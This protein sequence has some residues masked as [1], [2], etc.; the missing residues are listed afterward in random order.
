[1][2]S[3]DAKKPG[4]GPRFGVPPKFHPIFGTRRPAA[5]RV[6]L[7]KVYARGHLY[8]YPCLLYL[9]AVSGIIAGTQWAATHGLAGPRVY[10]AMLLLLLPALVGARLLF[11]AFHWEVYRHQP[12]RIWRRTE[13]GAALYGGLILSFLISLPVLPV[14]GLDVLAFWDAGAIALLVGMMFTRVGCLLNGCCIGRPSE[15]ALAFDLSD[16][17]GVRCRRLPL[18]LFEAGLCGLVLF[19]SLRLA[20]Q[21]PIGGS[22]FFTA[23]AGYGA[24]R[25]LLEPLRDTID[26]I[27]G[28]S[29]NRVIS[30]GLLALATAA[31][32]LRIVVNPAAPGG[33]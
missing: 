33:H 8:A 30:A 10:A 17:R 20:G 15:S 4:S 2:P 16:V 3:S 13:G 12:G 31:F 19:G 28:V 29:V 11:V 21:L 5:E 7:S 18:Q 32:L 25:W 23:L 6:N 14:L 26:R 9:G 22:L 27:G 1:M 24:G